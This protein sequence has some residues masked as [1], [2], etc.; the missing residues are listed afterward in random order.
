MSKLYFYLCILIVSALFFNSCS[1]SYRHVTIETA[2]PSEFLLPNDIVSLTLMNRSI[3]DEF[4]NYQRDS[5]QQYFY[6]KEY[7]LSTI[8]LDSLAADTT[9]KVL[10][11]LL[12][13][14]G[15]Y[16][17]V[18]PQ[19]YNIYRGLKFYK[20]PNKLEWNYVK[21]I[22]ELYDTDAL[23][24]IER[25]FNKI[26]TSYKVMTNGYM[27]E[28]YH[29]GS[30]DSKYDAV[31]KIYDPGREKIIRQMVVSDTIF[32]YHD[33][34]NQKKLFSRLPRI[35]KVLIQTAIQTAFDID[36]KL[37]PSWQ[38]ETRGYFIIDTK[39]NDQVD[40]FILNG[41]YESAQQYWTTYLKSNS[42]NT[43][44]KAEYN[45]AL[46]NEMQGKIEEAIEWANKSFNSQYRAQ[47]ENYLK[48]LGKRRDTLKKFEQFRN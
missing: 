42:R 16:D 5:L 48:Q 24:V 32:W 30:I 26:S 39:T 7:N 43:R 20:M 17:V 36:K 10:G 12:Y 37:S 2:K 23:L 29:E 11:E 8:I 14:S 22:C 28:F 35:K 33:D 34:I 27:S 38:S 4:K 40:Q 25:Y 19:E 6:K 31:V 15:R 18:I 13:E 44:S 3:N 46:V 9:L 47:T 45:M 21:N 1:T 41:E